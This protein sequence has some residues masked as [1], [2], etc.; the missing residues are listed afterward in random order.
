MKS[1]KQKNFSSFFSTML[2]MRRILDQTLDDPQDGTIPT[3]LQVRTLS[4]VQENPLIIASELAS[5]MQM[6]SSAITQLTD[7]LVKQKLL[8]RK[9]DTNDRR[10][11]HLVL[12]SYGERYIVDILKKMEQKANKILA[13]ISAQDLETIVRILNTFLKEYE[14]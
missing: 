13:P 7:R 4:I 8:S 5:K 1:S 9:I 11:V 10:L 6:S 12:S 14:K 2:K 3:M